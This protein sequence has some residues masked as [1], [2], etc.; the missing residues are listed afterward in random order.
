MGIKLKMPNVFKRYTE[1]DYLKAALEAMAWMRPR[2]ALKATT[3][4]VMSR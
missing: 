1:E 2:P 4:K 3:T